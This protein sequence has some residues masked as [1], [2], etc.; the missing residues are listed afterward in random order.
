MSQ[1]DQALQARIRRD[2]S[3]EGFEE[4]FVRLDVLHDF[5]ASGRIREATSLTRAE[6]Q[7][8]LE[9]LIF[10]LRETVQELQSEQ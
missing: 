9:E 8:W 2:Y 5:A 4:M 1:F 3:A 7:G 6:L 10:T